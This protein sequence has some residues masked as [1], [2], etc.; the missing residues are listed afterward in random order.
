MLLILDITLIAFAFNVSNYIRYGSLDLQHQ[1]NVFFV[2]FTLVWW[3]VSGFK[4]FI[5]R[6]DSV[7]ACDKRFANVVNAFIMHAFIL[8][9]CI[10]IFN[11]EALSRLLLLY[12]YLSTALLI[13]FSRLI[14]Q[15][16]N[17]YF[18]NSENASTKFVIVG[19]GPAA[20]SLH[21]TF[22]NDENPG[23]RFMGF[24]DDAPDRNSPYASQVRGGVADLKEYCL[25]NGIDEI[26]Y[27]MPLTSKEQ[28]DDLSDFADNNFM[29]FRIVPD[30]SAIVKR[31]VNM[32]L[33][34][35]VPMI[36]IRK[37]PLELIS[38][39]IIKRAFDIA[40]SLTVIMFLFPIILPLIALAIRLDSKG[41][42]FFKQL[43]PGKKN[44]LF[45]CYKFR[46]MHVNNQT[47][48]QATKHDPR[49]TRVGRFL[50]KTNLDE[51]PQFFNVLLGD[52]SVV[53]PRPNLVSQLDHYSKVITKYKMRHFVTPGITGYAQVS[54]Y[55]GETKELHL[56]EKRV[57][58]DVQYMENWSF[59]MDM[60]I[61]FLT[62]WNMIKGEKNAY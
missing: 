6:I 12:T 46:T 4:N 29:Y 9:S 16:I 11:L 61:I 52:M 43:R 45:V 31:D 38:N 13:G 23:A 21:Q 14:L 55:R 18:S 20:M 22:S 51:I 28:I 30:F 57:E 26:Y 59:M 49:V 24:F 42:I 36:S 19:T 25:E 35:N 41:P 33:Y 62:V 1:Y 47:E 58:Y 8:A 53:G 17:K 32:Y 10:V 2:L 5:I 39:R 48:V 34:N 40:F 27:A 60:K 50:R 54:G 44:R 37:E 3:I 7:I 15:L 56:M